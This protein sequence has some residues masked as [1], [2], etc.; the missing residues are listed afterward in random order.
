MSGCLKL[1]FSR[2]ADRVE[3]VVL[4]TSG[5]LT[6]GDR[7]SLEAKAKAGATLSLTT[8]AAERAYLAATGH[9]E[10]RTRL[11][12]EEAATLLW[13]PQELILFEGAQLDRRLHCH[14]AE[15]S[16]ALIVEPV[17]F[18]RHAMGEE[19]HNVRFRDE[20]HVTR[21]GLPLL[22]DVIDLSGDVQATLA[23]S[24]TGADAGAMASIIYVA[25]D[26]EAQMQQTR[27]DL[28][29]TAGVSLI[30]NDMLVVRALAA[31]SLGLRRFLLPL[32]DRLTQN[33]VPVCWRL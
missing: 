9:A 7:L 3:A 25:P 6:S 33:S 31:D 27:A 20:I 21:N 8:Q 11:L 19:L 16:R 12:A 26:A 2:S 30:Q 5:G 29:K 18:G 32:L 22:S 13:L 28:P 14:L 10:V 1:L 23:R 15:G 4:N 24:V 17:V